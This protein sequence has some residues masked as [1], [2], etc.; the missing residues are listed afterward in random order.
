MKPDCLH[1]ELL[2]NIEIHLLETLNDSARQCLLLEAM[3]YS[4]LSGG[5]R[6]RPL[7]TLATGMMYGANKDVLLDVG[8]AIEL[9][10]CYSLIHDD[11]PSMDD[12]EL[13]RGKP[14]CHRKFS[15]PIAIL[16]GDALQSLAFQILSKSSLD[17]NPEIKLRIVNLL[18]YSLGVNGM[19]GGQM[20]DLTH[21]GQKVDMADLRIMHE[22]KTGAL[23]KSAILSGY[24]CINQYDSAV[25]SALSKVASKLGLL[26]QVVDDI[27]DIT[28]GTDILGKTAQKDQANNKA[29]YV[30]ILGLEQAR[31]YART[32]YLEI[33]HSLAGYSNAEFILYLTELIYNRNR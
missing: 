23:I 5:K 28:E 4:S 32:I 8:G 19:A 21:T 31:D 29:T 13:R 2:N 11:L 18:A 6:I 1:K 26:F 30:T 9:V 33:K 24:L 3:Q 16:A 25:Y 17:L 12:D 14:T 22:M 7:L 10:H 27:I 20:L 15:E